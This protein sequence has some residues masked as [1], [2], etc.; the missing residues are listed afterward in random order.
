MVTE[1]GIVMETG[2]ES[3]QYV[4]WNDVYN[5]KLKMGTKTN[6]GIHPKPGT[7]GLIKIIDSW[8]EIDLGLTILPLFTCWS[9]KRSNSRFFCYKLLC[10]LTGRP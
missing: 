3:G 5:I 7:G 6:S 1:V 2:L 8:L 9:T 4:A 10:L